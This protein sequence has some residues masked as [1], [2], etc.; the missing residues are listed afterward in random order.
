[1]R[2]FNLEI[3]NNLLEYIKS[4]YL[5][6]NFSKTKKLIIIVVIVVLKQILVQV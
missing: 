3:K 6:K 2:K 4:K 5:Y 1:M